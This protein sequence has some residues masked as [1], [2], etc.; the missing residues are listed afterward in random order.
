MPSVSARGKRSSSS[1]F[2][3]L[4]SSARGG[5]G[6]GSM[7]RSMRDLDLWGGGGGLAAE[8][9]VGPGDFVAHPPPQHG[10][11][12][13]RERMMVSLQ[14]WPAA[15]Q[16]DAAAPLSGHGQAAGADFK[17]RFLRRVEERLDEAEAEDGGMAELSE[18]AMDLYRHTFERLIEEFRTYG[19]PLSR[20]K[21]A[22]DRNE[23]QLLDRIADMEPTVQ[24]FA[25]LDSETARVVAE[26]TRSR[27]Q[28]IRELNG[29][30]HDLKGQLSTSARVRRAY[31]DLQE[32]QKHT[33]VQLAN[34]KAE[35]AAQHEI[36]Q[37]LVK[38]IQ[39]H[40]EISKARDEIENATLNSG[41]TLEQRLIK[42]TK[43]HQDLLELNDKLQS[44]LD[45]RTA[46]LA[47]ARELH[48]QLSTKFDRCEKER[49]AIMTDYQKTRSQ[50]RTVR[51]RMRQGTAKGG[52][53]TKID[54]DTGRPLTARPEWDEIHKHMPQMTFDTSMI[55]DSGTSGAAQ[56]LTE[57]LVKL[58]Y[59]LKEA[60]AALPWKTAN[61]ERLEEMKRQ[62]EAQANGDGGFTGKW[63][64]C[65]GTGHN[66]PKFL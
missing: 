16:A 60:E 45:Q 61:E 12:G 30:V 10:G 53:G 52:D 51:K 6:G 32:E 44:Q 34:T 49:V 21:A 31:K 56:I 17:P 40:E 54:P 66:V 33:K 29:Q 18:P 37:S 64:V 27:D 65:Q 11:S 22:Y 1:I 14:R 39:R 2:P 41:F 55:V 46:A 38:T 4:S 15:A 19:P 26:A 24:Q 3:M 5:G 8:R 58:S 9:S 7:A 36:S 43:E 23:Q 42:L 48:A 20:I 25:R 59:D 35:M 62:R 63:F 13:S 28:Q 50:Y 57:W 47:Q